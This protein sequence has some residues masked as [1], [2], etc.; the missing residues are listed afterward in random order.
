MNLT[1]ASTKKW[2]KQAEMEL[3]IWSQSLRVID[4]QLWCCCG[5]A[6]IVVF[7][8]ELRQLYNIQNDDDWVRDV[9]EINN[10]DVVMA[11]KRDGLYLNQNGE[12]AR[13]LTSICT[14]IRPITLQ[15]KIR[16]WLSVSLAPMRSCA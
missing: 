9:A 4:Q 1:Q 2:V 14:M 16:I 7:D 13:R 10:G 3:P 15:V 12:F 5:D 6:G 8:S 11:K